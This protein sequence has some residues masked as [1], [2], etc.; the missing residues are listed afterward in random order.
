MSEE[1][2]AGFCLKSRCWIELTALVSPPE[3]CSDRSEQVTS[4]E[5]CGYYEQ[6][7]PTAYLIRRRKTLKNALLYFS[8]Y[9]GKAQ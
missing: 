1:Q 2:K 9:Q 4:C 8:H 7:K 3:N 6:R 5:K